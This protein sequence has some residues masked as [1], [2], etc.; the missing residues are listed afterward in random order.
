MARSSKRLFVSDRGAVDLC[1]VSGV[2]IRRYVRRCR[3]KGSVIT[4]SLSDRTEMDLRF[5]S[6]K[7][8]EKE[9]R[10]L[11]KDWRRYMDE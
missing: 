7:K 6:K 8:A 5:S 11:L 4:I 3:K 1:M 10:R 2:H 9:F